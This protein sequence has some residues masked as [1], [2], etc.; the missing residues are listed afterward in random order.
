MLSS[1]RI[2]EVECLARFFYDRE[3]ECSERFVHKQP[4]VIANTTK[5]CETCAIAAMVIKDTHSLN[6]L[7]PFPLYRYVIITDEVHSFR[8]TDSAS[9]GATRETECPI[10]LG[11]LT[12]PRTLKCKHVFCA[13]CVEITLKHN[14][15]CPVCKDVQ[16]VIQGNQPKGE[17]RIQKT[18][19]RLPGYYG[20]LI[21]NK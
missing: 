14:N 18:N 3:I 5:Q 19:D 10:C 2:H 4:A 17:M 21:A 1:K 13:K 12:N 16:G 20:T 15:R 9:G 6:Y 7:Q 8:L 11:T